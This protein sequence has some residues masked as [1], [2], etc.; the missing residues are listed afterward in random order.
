MGFIVISCRNAQHITLSKLHGNVKHAVFVDYD[1]VQAGGNVVKIHK[2]ASQGKFNDLTVQSNVAKLL[3]VAG[4][5][6]FTEIGKGGEVYVPGIIHIN[7]FSRN[8]CRMACRVDV[9]A[10][11]IYVIEGLFDRVGVHICV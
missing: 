5:S 10:G 1:L 8:G 7:R 4:Y 9:N 2:A 11:L 6:H 3:R